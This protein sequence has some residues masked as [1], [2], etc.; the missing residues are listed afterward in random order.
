M[1]IPGF[2][3]HWVRPSGGHSFPGTSLR[4]M[5]LL[6]GQRRLSERLEGASR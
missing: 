3:S 4:H 2:N 1:Y 5:H 6:D